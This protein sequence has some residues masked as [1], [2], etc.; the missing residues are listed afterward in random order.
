MDKCITHALSVLAELALIG[1]ATSR[2]HEQGSFTWLQRLP[3]RYEGAMKGGI[4][5]CPSKQGKRG[6][7][8]G[9]NEGQGATAQG[10]SSI[11]QQQQAQDLH[12]SNG[13]YP[14]DSSYRTW[15]KRTEA[16][17]CSTDAAIEGTCLRF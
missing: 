1:P 6:M 11:K 17:N 10:D 14:H 7:D 13:I 12:G 5:L 8:T 15:R 3:P 4:D 9:Q 2:A 16:W